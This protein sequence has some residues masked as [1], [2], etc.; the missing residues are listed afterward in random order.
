M[1]RALC[2]KHLGEIHSR[3]E[4]HP[5]LPVVAQ[6]RYFLWNGPFYP[7]GENISQEFG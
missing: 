7:S 2:S 6:F 1:V 4:E 5:C 3:E